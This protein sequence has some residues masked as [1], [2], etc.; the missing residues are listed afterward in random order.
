MNSKIEEIA[1]EGHSSSNS[2]SQHRSM[3]SVVKENNW[4]GS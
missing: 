1:L 3:Q 4:G 2:S